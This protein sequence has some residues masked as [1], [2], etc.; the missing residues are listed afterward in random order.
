MTSSAALGAF[1]RTH[2]FPL[3][4]D[5][6]FARRGRELVH[7]GPG[8]K[9]GVVGFYSH[10]TGDD[11]LG[12][13]VQYGLVSPSCLSRRAAKGRAAPRWLSPSDALLMV[14]AMTPDPL[15]HDGSPESRPF[16]WTFRDREESVVL[17]RHLDATVRKEV[18]PTLR[19]WYDTETLANAILERREGAFILMSP[20]ARAAAVA[21]LDDG[22]SA[23]LDR[24]L[25]ELPQD[26]PVRQWV[27]G[28]LRYLAEA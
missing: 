17:G 8:G 15:Q 3:L 25:A 27:E 7:E 21:L 26:D 18:I 24:V 12:F 6:G 19:S 1:L 2:A 22:P 11:D 9:R 13:I 10:D 20:P 4:E 14:Q 16:R 5:A 28:V 23:R